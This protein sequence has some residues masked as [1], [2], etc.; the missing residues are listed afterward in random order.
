[1]NNTIGN[2]TLDQTE[3]DWLYQN[4]G[5]GRSRAEN[6]SILGHLPI[7][8]GPSQGITIDQRQ[9]IF[10]DVI[11]QRLKVLQEFVKRHF[12]RQKGPENNEH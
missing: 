1:M 10:E 2:R 4:A 12:V 7:Q 9:R 6:D 5:M 3:D 8:S 11:V